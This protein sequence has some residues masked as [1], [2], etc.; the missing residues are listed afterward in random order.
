M[1]KTTQTI[2]TL[3]LEMLSGE[4]PGHIK[5]IHL[6]VTELK[7]DALSCIDS[8]FIQR[9]EGQVSPS[10]FPALAREKPSECDKMPTK[11]ESIE[12]LKKLAENGCECF[13]L[14]R[15]NLRSSKHIYYDKD[16]NQFEI[17]NYIDGSEQCLSE[18]ELMEKG[19]TNIGYAMKNGALY[20]G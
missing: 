10:T 1:I 17:I 7:P 2:K 5:E 20:K 9:N 15:G 6:R 8:F 11:I 12:E 3:I 16:T 18:I 14:L 13:I 19:Y 4:G